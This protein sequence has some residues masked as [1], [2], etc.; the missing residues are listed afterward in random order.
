MRMRFCPHQLVVG[1]VTPSSGST[2]GSGSRCAASS[3]DACS[4]FGSSLAFNAETNKV[5]SKEY[6]DE[7]ANLFTSHSL[8]CP[9]YQSVLSDDSFL[10]GTSSTLT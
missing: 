6:F 10:L 5:S 8:Q 4:K 2:S 3:C 7:M 9:L 1:S